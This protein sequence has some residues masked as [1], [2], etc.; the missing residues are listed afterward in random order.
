MTDPAR[1]SHTLPD[2][3]GW[4]RR[5]LLARIG[6]LGGSAAVYRAV[7]ALGLLPEVARAERPELQPVNGARTVAI[8]GAGM[9]GL[10]A[11][12]ELGRAGYRCVI[13]EASARVG[14]RNLTLRG[15]ERVDELGHPQTCPFDADPE[16]YLNAGA[17]RIPTNH[18]TVL[19]YCRELGVELAPIV[20]E[21]PNAWIQD[22]AM[23]GGRP[24]RSHQY[25]DD[26]R[27]FLAELLAKG[28][29]GHKLDAKLDEGD[30][31]RLIELLDRF[32]DL[33]EAH[34]YRSALRT[35]DVGAGAV[36]PAVL[37]GVYDFKELLRSRAAVQALFGGGDTR[38]STMLEPVGGMDRIVD[39]FLRK[40]GDVVQLEAC[41]ESIQLRPDGVDVFYRK[42]GV[43]QKL[44]ADYCLNSIPTQIMA[45]IAHNF[46]EDY[47]GAFRALPRG[48][49]FK[50]GLQVRERF[51]EREQIYGGISWTAQDITQIWYPTHGIHGRKGVLLAAYTWNDERGEKFADLAPAER[52]ELA[53]RQGEKLHPAYRT[54]VESGVSVAWHRMNHMLGCAAH[55]TD[56]LRAKWLERLRA[57]LGGHYMVGDQVSDHPAWQEGAMQTALHA[58]ADIDRRERGEGRRA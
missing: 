54:Y 30:A 23:F 21:N 42:G 11:A 5:E 1:G 29:A 57:P 4:S 41:V 16:L 9:A 52:I 3:S 7:I 19:A 46:P 44:A 48:K 24:V 12:Y 31:E 32:G 20:N 22:D 58:I 37:P 53:I 39:G 40:L 8:L 47:A 33:D 14:G 6:A 38:G 27:G 28:V 56:E 43:R 55:W 51:W 2:R 17:A 18:T 13:L 34:L 49:F 36:E 15:G 45:G 26:T 35:A 25:A 10:T 50:L